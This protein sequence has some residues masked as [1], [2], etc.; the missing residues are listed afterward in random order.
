MFV[1]SRQLQRCVCSFVHKVKNLKRKVKSVAMQ[2]AANSPAPQQAE[3]DGETVEPTDTLPSDN[4]AQR[5]WS[6]GD[7]REDKEQPLEVLLKAMN[8]TKGLLLS[9]VVQL[10]TFVETEVMS[11]LRYVTSLLQQG[12]KGDGSGPSNALVSQPPPGI[13]LPLTSEEELVDVE[14]KLR[15]CSK[16][17]RSLVSTY[18]YRFTSTTV[19]IAV[20]QFMTFHINYCSIQ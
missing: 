7:G 15:N 4:R 2:P 16:T 6:V 14:L 17:T 10:K 13:S 8:D 5:A 19:I 1:L 9:E 20:L 12:L 18:L 11:Q 3:D